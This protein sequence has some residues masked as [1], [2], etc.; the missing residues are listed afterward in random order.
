M[1]MKLELS[2]HSFEKNLQILSL[3]KIRPVRAEFFPADGRT[4]RKQLTVAFRN[5]A[6]A[7]KNAL[8]MST[9]PH[10]VLFNP[11]KD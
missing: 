4:D 9:A 1:L 10:A 8:V 2:R 7:P 5:F 3:M 11:S 6:G